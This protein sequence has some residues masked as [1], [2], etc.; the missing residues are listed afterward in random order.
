VIH[1]YAIARNLRGLP[2]EPG[3][4]CAPLETV[5][6][7]GATAVV[8]RT[9]APTTEASR[10]AL[11]RH[12]LVVEALVE[13]AD[14]VL[15]VRFGQ[16]FRDANDLRTAVRRLRPEAGARLDRLEGCVEV[17]VRVVDRT[18]S[19][20]PS[21]ADDGA[22]YM[23][24]KLETMRARDC[25]VRALS[26]PLARRAA[27]SVLAKQGLREVVHEA[28][29]LV[30]RESVGDFTGVVDRYVARNP[31]LTVLCTGPW[32]PHSFAGETEDAP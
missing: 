9:E 16:R 19:P 5:E 15:P 6:V 25:L 1:L 11:V 17:G 31:G 18:P 2:T 8:S 10:A 14:G 4:D 30:R 21:K 7:D 3:F 32:A 28:A 29:Y 26:A 22:S 27:A 23:Q 13:R 20:S 24:E 12:G